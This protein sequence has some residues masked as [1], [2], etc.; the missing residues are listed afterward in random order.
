M[1]NIKTN[2]LGIIFS[3]GLGLFVLVVSNYFTFFNSILL[4]LLVGLQFI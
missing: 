2:P 3:L 1:K 4:G